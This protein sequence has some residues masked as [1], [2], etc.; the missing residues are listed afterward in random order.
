M[1]FEWTKTYETLDEID[2]DKRGAFTEKGGEFVLVQAL[3]KSGLDST[4]KKKKAEVAEL[5][6]QIAKFDGLDPDIDLDTLPDD[7]DELQ[8]LRQ[9]KE[10]G[11]LEGEE[12]N[13]RIEAIVTERLDLIQKKHDRELKK[14]EDERDAAASERDGARGELRDIRLDQQITKLAGDKGVKPHSM[15]SIRAFGREEFT[16]NADGEV[17]DK[18]ETGKTLEDWM[19]NIV[20]ENPQFTVDL[21]NAG[22]GAKPGESTPGKKV[23]KRTEFDEI[24]ATDPKRA[25]EI[26]ADVR[27]GEAELVEG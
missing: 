18:E 25:S 14:V 16:V 6:K 20:A 21:S 15:R 13:K 4:L 2:E 12:A 23:F 3:D 22:T 1:T 7:L 27:K 11:T 10:A 17:V 8:Q 24:S 26:M 5:K 19:D 9:A